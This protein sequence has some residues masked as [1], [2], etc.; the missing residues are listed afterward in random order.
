MCF[1]TKKREKAQKILDDFREVFADE[2]ILKIG[3]NLKYDMLILGNYGIETKGKLFD[4][5]LAHYLIQPEQ[6]HNLDYLCEIYLNY[7]KIPT[8]SLSGKKGKNQLN[9]RSV[10]KEKLRDYACEDADLTFRLKDALEP[11]LDKFEMRELF[12]TIEMPLVPVLVHMEQAGVKLD[13]E[14][15]KK[16]AV[17]LESKSFRWKRKFLNSRERSSTSHRQ[18]SLD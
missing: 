2:K 5:M 9:M 13:I 15:L 3:Q 4:T 1:T 18:N 10:P 7:E 12:E 8:A 6:R 14:E 11:E 16:Y 17:T